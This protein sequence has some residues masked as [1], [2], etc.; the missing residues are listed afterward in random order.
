[1]TDPEHVK[2]MQQEQHELRSLLEF[3]VQHGSL[4]DDGSVVF[5]ADARERMETFYA[6][7]GWELRWKEIE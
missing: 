1:M 5:D 4:L 7:K 3:V 6:L 2:A